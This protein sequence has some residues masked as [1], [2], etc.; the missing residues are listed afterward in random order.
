[1]ERFGGEVMLAKHQEVPSMQRYL[2]WAGGLVL[3][4]GLILVARPA[5]AVIGKPPPLGD[6]LKDHQFIFTVKVDTL[7][8]DKPAMVLTV[9]EDLKGKAPFRRLP[10]NLKGDSEAEKEKQVPQLLKRLAP[11]LPL[12]LFVHERGKNYITFAYTNGSWFQLIGT[13][14]DDSETVHWRFTHCEP[15]FRRTYKD[16]TAD[17][18]QVVID[19]LTG[20]KGLPEPD[21]KAEPGL[22][23]EVKSSDQPQPK[24]SGQVRVTRG[25]VFAV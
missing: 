18:R 5:Q 9:D 1:M 15:F 12:V 22:G 17:L 13:K 7:D 2:A 23:P 11:N 4:I 16:S 24:E 21:P 6:V 20:K 25:P 19:G 10:V 3:G 8:P 14:D